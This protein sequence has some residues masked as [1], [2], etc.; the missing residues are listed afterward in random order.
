MDSILKK[1]TWKVGMNIQVWNTPPELKTLVSSWESEGYINPTKKPDFM[2]AFVQKENEV[3]SLFFE[4]QKFATEDQQVWMAYPKGSSKRYK[5]EINRDSGWSYLGEFEYET[6]RQ[7]AIDE[8]WSALRF[9]K[10]K[11]VKIMTR[12]FSVKD[13]K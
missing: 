3:N 10:T 12:K 2:L 13:Q 4:M 11:Y 9:R 5:S 1:M 7:I 6:V 8:D